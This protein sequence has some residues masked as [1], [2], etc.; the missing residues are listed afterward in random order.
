MI[1]AIIFDLDG[2][3]I[4]SAEI[5]TRAFELLFA[6]YPDKVGEIVD[7]HKRNAGISRYI[8]FRYF[9]E[10]I[11]G[12]SLSSAE[13]VELGEKFSRIVLEQILKAPFVPGAIEFL[14]RNKNRYDFFIASGTPEEELKY[15]MAH[16][17]LS[18]FFREIHGTPKSKEDIIKD[19]LDRY[20][21]GRE[22]VVFVGDAESDRASADKVGVFFIARITSDNH[23]L[24]HCRWKA[25]DLTNL[26]I[27]LQDM[28]EK[29]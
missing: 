11:L 19:V 4:D 6:D 24:R 12:K 26:D 15:I 5:K 27:L 1:K 14:S 21:F 2:V 18:H 13:E 20:S 22:E 7:Y 28:S 23:H 29:K 9:Y 25:R 3:I 16:R 10:K 17:K 8:K